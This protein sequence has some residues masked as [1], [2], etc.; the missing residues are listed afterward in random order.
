MNPIG[1][2]AAAI[3]HPSTEDIPA[4]IQN[5]AVPVAHSE[6][7]SVRIGASKS[8]PAPVGDPLTKSLILTILA[9]AKPKPKRSAASGA[10]AGHFGGGSVDTG[11]KDW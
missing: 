3:F 5:S 9:K 8:N 2:N 10:G 7:A 1:R 4:Q 6:I 11:H